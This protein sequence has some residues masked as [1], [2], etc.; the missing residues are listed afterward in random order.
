M[1]KR[2]GITLAAAS[3]GLA[4]AGDAPI[5]FPDHFHSWTHVGSAVAGPGSPAAPK[6]E[7]VHHIYANPAAMAGYRSGKFPDGAVIVYDQ[8]SAKPLPNDAIAAGERKFI[9]V[10]VRDSR[11]FAATGGWGY[12]EFAWPD[13]TRVTA[14]EQNPQGCDGCHQ[15]APG[16]DRV[17]SSW[18]E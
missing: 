7:G 10:M 12:T 6:Y 15:A 3:V 18:R 2:I 11:R 4:A 1:R 9:D 8:W 16:Q 14:I 17:F 5:A 13:R